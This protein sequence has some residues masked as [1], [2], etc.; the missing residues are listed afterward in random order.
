M[1]VVLALAALALRPGDPPP[2]P[3]VEWSPQTSVIVGSPRVAAA[4]YPRLLRLA[5]G[6]LLCAFDGPLDGRNAVRVARSA[7]GSA[8]WSD[9]VTVSDEAGN[10]ANGQ[11]ALARSGELLCAYRLVDGA[12]RSIRVSRSPDGGRSW[13]PLSIV[14]EVPEGVW[15][16]HLF[17]LP[18]AR[19]AVFYATERR[20]PQAIAL[21]RSEDAGRSWLD[22][23]IVASHPASRDGMPVPVRLLTGEILVF[24]EAQDYLD[25][26]FV[27]RCTRS[28]DGGRSWTGRDLVYAS[29]KPGKKAGAPFAVALPGGEVV[30]SF[31]TDEDRNGFGDAFCD[32]KCVVSA[33]GGRT[34]SAPSTVF[35]A[36]DGHACWA[37]LLVD[38]P[39]EVRAVA[40]VQRGA[41]P[42]RI[43]MR[44][45]R[46]RR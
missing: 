5:D 46:L 12:N 19:L 15:E 7:R 25:R 26:P 9:P 18:S 30:V 45:G 24:F 27:V 20:R 28:T 6:A 2:L 10:A 44:R 8:T 36:P 43:E 4:Y 21:R 34:W 33:D 41:A 17:E 32:V 11:L 3:H 38:G 39:S 13:R 23:E 1:S 31:Q 40:S 22:E 16:P 37:S 14:D 35:S 29:G 42:P